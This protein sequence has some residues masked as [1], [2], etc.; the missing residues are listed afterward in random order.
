[1]GNVNVSTQGSGNTDMNYEMGGMILSKAVKEKDLGVIMNANMKVSE[2]CR[3]AA[4]KGNQVLGM[5]RRNIKY[6][7]GSQK[8][9]YWQNI[10][11][12]PHYRNG[13]QI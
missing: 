2:N 1:M 6:G 8:L 5:I 4:F 13:V 10:L 9:Y 12:P 3:I 11:S 7:Q